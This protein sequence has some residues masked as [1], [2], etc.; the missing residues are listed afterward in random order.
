M[1]TS[2]FLFS[3]WVAY[4]IC[5]LVFCPLPTLAGPPPSIS[6]GIWRSLP[7]ISSPCLLS[8]EEVIVYTLTEDENQGCS[9]PAPQAHASEAGAYYGG[10]S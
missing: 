2:V 8:F 3:L 5:S 6:P 9:S 10:R 4:E 7:A 1:R